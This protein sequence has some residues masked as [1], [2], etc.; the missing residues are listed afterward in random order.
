[1]ETGWSE[2]SEEQAGAEINTNTSISALDLLI[3]FSYFLMPR[4]IYCVDVF[5]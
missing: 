4:G 2:K 3:N 5:R 1:M